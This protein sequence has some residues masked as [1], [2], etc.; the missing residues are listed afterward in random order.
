[1][2][3]YSPGEEDFEKFS[4]MMNLAPDTVHQ[5]RSR[6]WDLGPK[7]TVHELEIP[8]EVLSSDLFWAFSEGRLRRS[9]S[10]ETILGGLIEGRKGKTS[11]ALDK[12]ICE[13]R[14][15][16]KVSSMAWPKAV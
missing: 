13:T 12:G 2:P 1:M 7:K 3:C 5:R 16:L 4:K 8:L 15:W 10:S 9:D 11:S 6:C 14:V